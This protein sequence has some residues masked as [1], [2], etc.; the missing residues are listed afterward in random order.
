M[1]VHFGIDLGTAIFVVVTALQIWVGFGLWN[2]QNWARMLFIAGAALSVAWIAAEGF[3]GL[4]AVQSHPALYTNVPTPI[5]V[6]TLIRVGIDVSVLAYLITPRAKL[7]F[8]ETEYTL[9]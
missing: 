1:P 9:W 2:L 8:A 7:A 6:G 3:L 5:I 4:W